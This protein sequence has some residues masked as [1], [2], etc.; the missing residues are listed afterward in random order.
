MEIDFYFK[1]KKNIHSI[2]GIN[3]DAYKDE[4]MRRRLD[5]WL[6]R[7]G[8]KDWNEYF[9]RVKSDSNEFARFRN[10]LTINVTEFFRDTDKWDQLQNRILPE[11]FKEAAQLYPMGTGLKVWSAGCSIGAES[12]S[13]AILLDELSRGRKNFL[14]ATDL[15]RGALTKAQ[16]GG[17][18]TEEDVKNI[19]PA[20]RTNYL[21]T[22]GA[23]HHIADKLIKQIT[24]REHNLL[25]DPYEKNLDLIVCRNVV[26]YFTAEAKDYI[27][28]N[29][30]AALRPG[31][32]L[33][34][35]GTEIIPRPQEIGFSSNGISFYKKII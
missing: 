34:V 29:F 10:Y 15:D 7:S 19:S 30:Q 9:D 1:L 17:P 35:G 32:I 13:L 33:F 14:L 22:A 3:L 31:G 24:F 5:A 28:K 4:Q 16:A 27:F 18:Y 20:R 25:S 26:I 8:A 11:L 23:P 12:Y 6:V 21:K 2:L